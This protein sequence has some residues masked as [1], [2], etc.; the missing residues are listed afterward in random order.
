MANRVTSAGY[1]DDDPSMFRYRITSVTSE[2]GA[3]TDI[4]YNAGT[5]KPGSPPTPSTNTY[6]CFPQPWTQ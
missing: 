2:T 3:Q 1:G 4:A 5:C 6:P